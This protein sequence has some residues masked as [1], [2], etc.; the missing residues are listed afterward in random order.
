MHFHLRGKDYSVL[1]MSVRSG[2]PYA[3]KWEK[4]GRTIVYE[5]HDTPKSRWAQEPKLIDQP[6]NTMCENGRFIQAV[7]NYKAGQ[8]PRLVK[9]YEKIQ[10]GIW[11]F[12]GYFLL[13]DYT[14]EVDKNS[15]VRK[16]CKFKLEALDDD[17]EEMQTSIMETEHAR[18]IPS[19]VKVEV[20]KRDKGCCRLCGSKDNLHYDHILPYSKGGTSTDSKN[21]QILCAKCNLKKGAKIV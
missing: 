14:Y 12:N 17:V 9:V 19:D 3:D 8:E 10:S 18:L 15:P 20:Y 11:V 1:N 7:K 16:V 4:D 5:G 6:I 2:A 13:T 21:I